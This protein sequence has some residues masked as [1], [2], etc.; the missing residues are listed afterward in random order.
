MKELKT[1]PN[2]VIKKADKD[3]ALVVLKTENFRPMGRVHFNDKETLINP[4]GRAAEGTCRK[5]AASKQTN[6]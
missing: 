1:N 4:T 6:A 2:I 3:G 5:Q